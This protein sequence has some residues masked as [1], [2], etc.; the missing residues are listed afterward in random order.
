M[1]LVGRGRVYRYMKR[2]EDALADFSRAIELDPDSED[3]KSEYAAIQLPTGS[4]DET[5]H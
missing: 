4:D 2:Y 5:R 3:S 1:A